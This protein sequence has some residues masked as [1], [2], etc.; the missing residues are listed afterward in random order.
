MFGVNIPGSVEFRG[1]R[2]IRGA[3]MTPGWVNP[4]EK[5]RVKGHRYTDRSCGQG[6]DSVGNVLDCDTVVTI[7]RETRVYSSSNNTVYYISS[8]LFS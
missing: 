5:R 4:A 8:H 2:A 7:N 1:R 3:N 6:S